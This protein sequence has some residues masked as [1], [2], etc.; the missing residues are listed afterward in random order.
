MVRS[1]GLPKRS[2]SR[3]GE[4]TRCPSS[5][6]R[7][8]DWWRS[9]CAAATA[10][11]IIMAYSNHDNFHNNATHK[12][13]QLFVRSSLFIIPATIYTTKRFFDAHVQ[14]IVSFS[15]AAPYFLFFRQGVLHGKRR[16]VASSSR[17]F[18]FLLETLFLLKWYQAELQLSIVA[19]DMLSKSLTRCAV[20]YIGIYICLHDI[21]CMKP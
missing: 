6:F 14:F 4:Q 21:M 9:V 10:T 13:G 17:G 20:P 5:G 12:C 18:L 7:L 16:Y 11:T 15:W 8:D 19:R 1:T 2:R 3:C